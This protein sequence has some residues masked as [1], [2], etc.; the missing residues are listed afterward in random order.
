M[1]RML[2]SMTGSLALALALLGPAAGEDTVAIEVTTPFTVSGGVATFQ[3]VGTR[4]GMMQVKL[5]GSLHGAPGKSGELLFDVSHAAS[6]RRSWNGTARLSAQLRVGA[7]FVG[8]GK[9]NWHRAHRAR[10]FV[11][12]ARGRRLY[13]PNHGIVDRPASTDGWLTLGGLVTTDVPIPLGWTDQGFDASKVTG[14]GVN[15]EAFNREGE[16][17]QGEIE[18]RDLQVTFQ[19]PVPPRLPGPDSKI[20]GGE[21]ARAARMNERLRALCGPGMAVGVNLAWPAVRAPDGKDLQLYGRLLDA[22]PELWWGRHWDL[23]DET[24]AQAVRADF[25]GIRELFGA[26]APV[27]LWLLADGRTTM[28]FDAQGGFTGLTER[29][30]A[31]MEVLVRL[32]S[33]EK[34]ALIPVLLDF[35]IADGV[36]R[37]GPD[38]AWP[39]AEHVALIT[40]PAQRRKLVAAIG[41]LVRPFAAHPAVLAWDV[42]N[43][44][45]NAAA[46]VTPEHFRDLQALVA[47]LVEAVHQ[48]GG[49]ATVGHRNVPDPR[50]FWR[51]R[52]A[53][54]L[55]QVHYYPLVETRPNP[56]PFG[57]DLGPVFGPLP[58]GWGELQA[59]PGHIAEQLATAA[60][61]GHRLFM[62]WS[63]RGSDE[64]GDGF[65]VRPHDE[66]IRRALATLRA[67]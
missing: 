55:G 56:T 5:R 14:V 36:A 20:R 47:E 33:E 57:V 65:A 58:A 40:D 48:A 9:R 61:A 1:G 24:V 62:F 53:I 10:L 51:G 11:E 37:S 25:R 22:G 64:N 54:D 3:P 46:V 44:P 19:R 17:V 63:W 31:N 7:P 27:R 13:L 50:R 16:V 32:A 26:G 18:L 52:A 15:V 2:S 29:T 67:R 60:R 49:L 30:R 34:V 41:D 38:G 12:D 42:M 59:E 4:R 8:D 43:E 21:R 35:H 45:G 6:L 23:G 28:S 39:V 66:E